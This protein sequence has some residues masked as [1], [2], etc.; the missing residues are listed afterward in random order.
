MIAT[1]WQ[2]WG[3]WKE[4]RETFLANVG[5]YDH[6]DEELADMINEFGPN[7]FLWLESFPV[8]HPH[9]AKQFRE[10]EHTP[11]KDIKIKPEEREHIYAA[12]EL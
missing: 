10:V 11:L 2:I 12:T 6:R 1:K 4:G 7:W 5:A 8:Q 9:T 3:R